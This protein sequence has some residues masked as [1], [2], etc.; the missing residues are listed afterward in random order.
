MIDKFIQSLKELA[1]N[2]YPIKVRLSVTGIDRPTALVTI[3]NETPSL[4]VHIHAVRV[5]YGY[6]W[7]TRAL[8]LLPAEKVTLQPKDKADWILSFDTAIL[9]ERRLQ[10]EPPGAPDPS[11][12][13]G[14]ESPAQLFNAIGMGDRKN[15]WIEVD[16]NE[17]SQREFLR[18][19][20][21]EVFDRIG[22]QH[23]E[24]RKRKAEQA[25]AGQPATAPQLKSEGNEKPQPESEWR[26]Q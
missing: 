3:V 17:Y 15:S 10:K 9:T 1:I 21:K 2:R 25:S 26:S 6:K 5:H 12:Q 8:T 14:I 16:F 20:V 4:T 19:K 11:S 7:F 24:I 13:P 23:R 18:K 22:K